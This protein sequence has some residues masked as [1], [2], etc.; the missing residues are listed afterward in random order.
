VSGEL[1]GVGETG[2]KYED[3]RNAYFD[4]LGT[5]VEL[6]RVEVL[7]RCIWVFVFSFIVSDRALSQLTDKRH[8]TGGRQT[9]RQGQRRGAYR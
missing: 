2:A 1:R 8:W 6:R 4:L 5:V 9:R 7:S 3:M